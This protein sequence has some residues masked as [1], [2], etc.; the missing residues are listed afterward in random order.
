MGLTRDLHHSI[1]ANSVRAV[2]KGG[3]KPFKSYAR[4]R[5]FR[6]Q[7]CKEDIVIHSAEGRRQ[8]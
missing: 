5:V 6:A 4:D 2:S 8:V 7:S 1:N 3:A